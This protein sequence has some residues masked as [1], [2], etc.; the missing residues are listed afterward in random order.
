VYHK[1]QYSVHCFS[2]N[3][4]TIYPYIINN[5]S[6]LTLFTD[7]TS[8][9]FSNSNST[10]YATEF[11]VTFDKINLWFTINSLSLNLYK[12]NYVHFTAK[13][14]TNIDI[15]IKFKDIQINNIYNIKFPGLTTDNTASWKK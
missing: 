15:N 14:N 4:V 7:D 10:D 3:T 1:V 8:I 13:S 5:I 9:I 12:T 2:Y 6:K 11:I